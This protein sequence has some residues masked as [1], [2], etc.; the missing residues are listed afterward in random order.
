MRFC[1]PLQTRRTL[2]REESARV[3]KKFPI[4]IADDYEIVRRRLRPLLET[5]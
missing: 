3:K 1:I 5:E 4:L 2:W